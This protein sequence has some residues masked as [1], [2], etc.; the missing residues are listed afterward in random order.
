MPEDFRGLETR[1]RLL[2]AAS[3]VFTAVGYA[4]QARVAIIPPMPLLPP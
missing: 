4:V 3:E 1:A 2:E